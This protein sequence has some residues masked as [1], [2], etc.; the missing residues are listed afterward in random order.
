MYHFVE[1]SLLLDD[2]FYIPAGSVSTHILSTVGQ[3]HS[4]Q[5]NFTGLKE[6]LH[7]LK[8]FRHLSASTSQCTTRY[9]QGCMT[10][11]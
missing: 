8:R 6:T 5:V 10:I 11:G 1:F 4:M 7:L 2:H 3:L 9:N